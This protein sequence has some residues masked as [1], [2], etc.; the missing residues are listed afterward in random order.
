MYIFNELLSLYAFFDEILSLYAVINENDCI[1]IFMSFLFIYLFF[2]L[3]GNS[4]YM[5]YIYNTNNYLIHHTIYN[6]RVTVYGRCNTNLLKQYNIQ[7][8]VTK[9]ILFHAPW[10]IYS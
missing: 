10:I 5:V 9:Y 4:I 6:V 3:L 7:K 2:L 1:H 8:H